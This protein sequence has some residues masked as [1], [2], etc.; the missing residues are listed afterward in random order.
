MD[1]S[2]QQ[3]LFGHSTTVTSSA[4]GLSPDILFTGG[5]DG[6]IMFWKKGAPPPVEPPKPSIDTSSKPVVS[7]PPEHKDIVMSETN[8]PKVISGRTVISDQKVDVTSPDL[9]IYVYDNSY[10][11]GDTMSLFFNGRWILDHYGV[12]KKKQP[13]ELK[14][15]PNT[16]NYLVLFA[17][18]LGKSPPNTAAIEFN[19]G[20]T[21]RMFK[22]SSDLK[23]CSAINF[24]YKK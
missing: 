16:N 18:N 15:T 23:S 13:V 6:R 2:I 20:K 8:I 5:L 11:D 19:D 10:L 4:F 22:L 3:E 7:N 24:Y 21:V 12:T 14:L 17:N 1:R 9:T